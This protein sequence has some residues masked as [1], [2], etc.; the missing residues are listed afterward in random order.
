MDRGTAPRSR[1]ARMAAFI[2]SRC[3]SSSTALSVRRRAGS[4]SRRLATVCF[5]VDSEPPIPRIS[6]AAV[7]HDDLVLQ[8]EDGNRFA[9]FRALPDGGELSSG[10]VILPD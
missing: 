6:G 9:A 10:V 2:S 5:D 4:S 1:W 3:D 8:S 7:S